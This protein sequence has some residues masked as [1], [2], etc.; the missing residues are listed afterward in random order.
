[1]GNQLESEPRLADGKIPAKGDWVFG[2]KEFYDEYAEAPTALIIAGKYVCTIESHTRP[3]PE[4]GMKGQ[5][6]SFILIEH[7]PEHF[8]LTTKSVTLGADDKNPAV[9]GLLFA[10]DSVY[11]NLKD[12]EKAVKDNFPA[13][14]RPRDYSSKQHHAYIRTLDA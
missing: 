9:T 6:V 11:S 12:A 4:N 5:M 8:N 7:S 3:T 10:P 1:M 2:V 14:V 13:P